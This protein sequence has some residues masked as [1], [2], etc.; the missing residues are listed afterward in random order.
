MQPH[1]KVA[2]FMPLK[3]VEIGVEVEVVNAHVQIVFFRRVIIPYL[4]V[5]EIIAVSFSVPSEVD[6]E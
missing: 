4:V 3:I 1:E 6:V 5:V 2:F